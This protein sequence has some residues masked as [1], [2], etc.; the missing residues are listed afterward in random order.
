MKTNH[1]KTSERK[2]KRDGTAP[3]VHTLRDLGRNFPSEEDPEGG[4]SGYA[5]IDKIGTTLMKRIGLP[6]VRPDLKKGS[7][8]GTLCPASSK[9]MLSHLRASASFG[10]GPNK[11]RQ[12]LLDAGS[13][14]GNI[15]LG[16]SAASGVPSIGIEVVQDR[17]EKALLLAQEVKELNIPCCL[18]EGNLDFLVSMEGITHL[19]MFNVG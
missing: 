4:S 6:G 11:S 9:R 14:Q 10:C 18:L 13:G 7:I 19:F 1:H 5:L 15:A 2:R 12:R 3:T 17:H 8:N 16:L